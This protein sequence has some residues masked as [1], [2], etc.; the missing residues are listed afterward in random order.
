MLT[1]PFMAL[2]TSFKTNINGTFSLLE[3]A[4]A[5]WSALPGSEKTAFR[6]LHV[7]T[8]EVYGT[9]SKTDAP[10]TE[11]D[12]LRPKQPVRRLK[13]RIGSPGASLLSHLWVARHYNQL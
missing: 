7:S 8:D 1:G 5:Y 10:F 13:S 6:F 2:Q 12:A 4:R 11:D 9:L 3:A